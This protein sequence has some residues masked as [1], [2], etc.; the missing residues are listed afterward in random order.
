MFA[1]HEMME[2]GWKI[3]PIDYSSEIPYE[4]CGN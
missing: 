3:E 1:G 4:W 2:I